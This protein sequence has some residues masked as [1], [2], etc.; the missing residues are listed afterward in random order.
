[1]KELKFIHITKCAGT[2]IENTAKKHDILFGKFHTEYGFWHKFFPRV[3]Q[4]VKEKYDWF[5]V[6]RNPYDRLL[7]EYYCEW[8]GI[9]KQNIVHTREEFNEYLINKITNRLSHGCHY[10]E[11]Y[12]YIDTNYTIHIIKFENLK[13]EL[14]ELYKKYNMNIDLDFDNKINSSFEKCEQRLFTVNDFSTELANLIHDVYEN[15]FTMFGYEK[16]S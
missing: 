9:G 11:Q 13:T 1:M 10:S 14:P 3:K 4:H 7:S 5:M 6:V 12:K 2:F 8:G 15:D 16:I